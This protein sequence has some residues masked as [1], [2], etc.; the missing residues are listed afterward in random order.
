MEYT[1]GPF[2]WATK[3]EAGLFFSEWLKEAQPVQ[4]VTSTERHQ[5]LLDL[6][7]QHPEAKNKIGVGIYRF[8]IRQNPIF[9]NQNTF[10]LIRVDGTS[11]DFSFRSCIS[12]KK[13]TAWASFCCAARNAVADQILVFKS[14]AFMAADRPACGITGNPVAWNN[15]HVDHVVEF[16]ELL[17]RFVEQHNIDV[18]TA[19]KPSSDMQIVAGFACDD[20]RRK[21]CEYHHSFAELRLTTPEANLSRKTK[22]TFEH[23]TPEE[24]EAAKQKQIDELKAWDDD[25]KR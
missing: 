8:E 21:W 2:S 18:D 19:I 7:K 25:R 9:R 1:A 14:A 24:F 17:R 4:I 3:K 15:C 12:G 20:L 11:T 5:C 13:K 22:G 6:I 23:V 10:Y 16:S